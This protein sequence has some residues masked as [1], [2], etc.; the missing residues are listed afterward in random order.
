M[1]VFAILRKYWHENVMSICHRGGNERS[2]T[3]TNPKMMPRQ[4]I[5]SGSSW[6]Y[7]CKGSMAGACKRWWGGPGF[8]VSHDLA[9]RKRATI[10][11]RC[12]HEHLKHRKHS[13]SDGRLGVI[14]SKRAFSE[15][16]KFSAVAK[17]DVLGKVIVEVVVYDDGSGC[18][19][20]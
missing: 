5:G 11:A 7:R 17:V 12:K 14:P 6:K 1:Q 13:F 18:S 2:A 20:S 8:R 3:T 15:R 4:H 9:T 10:W 19:G 16:I